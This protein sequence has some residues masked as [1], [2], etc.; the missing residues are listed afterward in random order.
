VLFKDDDA[1]KDF[2]K[3][4][5]WVDVILKNNVK[6]AI[7]LIGKFMKSQQLREFLNSLD[8]NKIEIFCHGYSHSYLPFLINRKFGKNR[9]FKIEFDKTYKSHDKSLKKYRDAESKYLKKKA[10]AFG[11]PGNQWNEDV[12][13]ALVENDFKLMFSWK[14]V[15][16]G[17]FTI[18]ISNNFKQNS[19][20]E[21][22]KDYEKNKNDALFVLQFHHA[23]LSDKQFKLMAE[24]ID[25]LKNKENRSFITPSELL[26]LSKQ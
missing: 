19:L 21:F 3:L 12:P 24:V 22:I 10:I 7:G 4:K 13:K 5:K 26:H 11:P 15:S 2:D 18:F 14:K 6:A 16:P 8:P 17:I 9:F 25:F 23:N 20:E 1:G